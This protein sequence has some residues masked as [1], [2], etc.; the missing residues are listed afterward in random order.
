MKKCLEE[1]LL[2]GI[3]LG[4]TACKAAVFSRNGEILSLSY[5]EYPLIRLSARRIEQSAE[6]WWTLTKES[7][8][9]CLSKIPESYRNNVI[10]LGISAQGISIVPVNNKGLPISNAITWLDSRAEEEARLLIDAIGK[11]EIYR[12]TGIQA[13]PVYMLP[14]IMWIKKNWPDVYKETYKFCTCQDYLISRLVGRYITDYS[15]AGGSLMHDVQKLGWS[16]EMLEIVGLPKEKLPELDWAGNVAGPIKKELASEFGIPEQTLIVLGGHDQECS[17]IGAGLQLGEMTISYGTASTLLACIEKPLFDAHMRVPCLP[18]VEKNKW[19]ME[20]VVSVGGA[21]QRWMRDLLNGFIEILHPGYRELAAVDYEQVINIA[22]KAEIGAGDVFFYPHMTGATSPYWDSSARGAFYGISMATSITHM[23]R[24]VIEG[25]IFQIKTNLNVLKEITYDPD[26][27]IIFGGGAR[28]RFIQQATADI[29]NK[30]VVIPDTVEA[31]L[32]GACILAGLGAGI[33]K[34]V[35]SAQK[36]V[37]RRNEHV[38]PIDENVEK[39]S[40]I[41]ERY[42]KTEQVILAAGLTYHHEE[43]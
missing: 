20:A 2:I 17:G 23:I 14:K 26:H 9:E 13:N 29:L 22:N 31:S 15:I 27:V 33:Y 43:Q 28:N 16:D 41:Y 10:A 39:Y 7:I 32:L 21:G 34:D 38:K 12:K 40:R 18:S 36:E 8:K 3:D 37:I 30:P 1:P 6:L 42:L 25:W 5:R 35:L 19:V 24:A 11:E 4:T